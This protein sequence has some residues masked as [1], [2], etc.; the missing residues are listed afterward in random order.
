MTPNWSHTA[1]GAWL[2]VCAVQCWS[3]ESRCVPF[4]WRARAYLWPPSLPRDDGQREKGGGGAHQQLLPPLIVKSPPRACFTPRSRALRSSGARRCSVVRQASGG[5]A[6]RDRLG[7]TR[8]TGFMCSRRLE[9]PCPCSSTPL[10]ST[11]CSRTCSATTGPSGRRM[12]REV[13]RG[14]SEHPLS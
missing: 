14:H 2:A 3:A 12:T 7:C 10:P 8:W 11:C 9:S 6:E 4:K 5:A 1:L 13:R